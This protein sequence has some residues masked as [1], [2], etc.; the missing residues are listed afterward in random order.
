MRVLVY[1]VSSYLMGGI[2]TFLFNMNSHMSENCIFDYVIIGNHTIHEKE[3]KSKGGKIYFIAPRRKMKQNMCDWKN[4]LDKNKKDIDVVYFNLFSLSWIAPVQLCRKLGYSVVVHSHNNNL[5]DCGF[6]LKTMHQINK[7]LLKVMKITRLTNS[8]L[9]SKFMFGNA[10]EGQMIYNAISVNRFMFRQD[11]R[12]RVRLE[13]GLS[14]K[15]VYGFSGRV[16][17]QKNPL[18]LVEI[19]NEIRKIDQKAVLMIAGDGNLMDDLKASIKEKKIR[20]KVI[21]LGNIKNIEDFYQAIDVYILPSRFEGLGIVLI[22]AQTAGLPC[23]TSADVVPPEAKATDLLQYVPLKE[24]P[25]EW[26]EA[27]V[28]A[29]DRNVDRTKYSGQIKSSNFNIEIEAKRLEAIL[30]KATKCN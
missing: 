1:G 19:F 7:L 12:D 23:L 6:V 28:K 25:R 15:H 21:L 24:N 27:A 4:I 29:L 9:S 5:H 16:M 11:I 30:V 18:F 22:E 3:I 20:D 2:E 8:K 13:Y 26:A 14:D 17:Y 10:K